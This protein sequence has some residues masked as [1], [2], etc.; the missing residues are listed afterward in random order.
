VEIGV[1]RVFLLCPTAESGKTVAVNP[2]PTKQRQTMRRHLALTR[3]FATSVVWV[4]AAAAAHACDLPSGL[5]DLRA[6]VIAE[7]NAERR[8]NGLSAL[9]ADGRLEDAA[10][11]LACDNAA[12]QTVSHTSANGAGLQ[13]R[14]RS[15]GYR[16]SAA[17]ENVQTGAD[18]P[19]DVV[20]W[21]MGS[22]GHRTNILTRGIGDIGVGIAVSS[23]Q[24]YWVINMGAAR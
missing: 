6:Q 19:S 4:L 16:F 15:V 5:S 9:Q 20:A 24:V 8:A 1:A 2:S 3:V 18:S 21:W 17:S 22:S 12:R 10:Q 14:L 13:G 23:G 7:V 11:G